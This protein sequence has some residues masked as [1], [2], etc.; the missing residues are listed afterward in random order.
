MNREVTI[1]KALSLYGPGDLRIIDVP[2]PVEAANG[3]LLQVNLVGMCGSDLNSYRGTNPLVAYPRILGHEVAATVVEGSATVPSGSRVTISPYTSCGICASCLRGRP[4]A[5]QFNQTFGVQRDGAATELLR[6]AEG[7]LFPSKLSLSELCLV[8]PLTV[9]F[10]AAARGQI[11]SADTVVVL[12]CG[13]V[14]LGAIAGSV[15]RGARTIAV[16][17]DDEKLET[18]RQLGAEH[19]IHSGREPLEQVL[20]QLTDGKGPDAIIEAIGSPQTFR[21]AV[22]LVAFTGRV[23]YIG[24]AKEP[25]AYETRLFVQ[26][27]LD[28]RGSRNALPEDF[29]AVISMLESG[30]VPID[31]IISAV[32]PMDEAPKLMAKWAA[33]PSSFTKIMIQVGA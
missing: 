4:N 22:E 30:R 14:G 3:L 1:L 32:V 10:H 12:G 2:A 5:C 15:F 6:V 13:G 28:I 16:D 8:E 29:R 9:G 7:K 27:E 19:T 23:V 26:K 18:A 11:A 20:Q 24:Y 25:V 21:A 31:R 33:A 17:V